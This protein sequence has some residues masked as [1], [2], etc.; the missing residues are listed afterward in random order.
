M[1]F[2]MHHRPGILSLSLFATTLSIGTC[3]IS[4]ADAQDKA[5]PTTSAPTTRPKPPTHADLYAAA[6]KKPL[7]KVV[8]KTPEGVPLSDSQLSEIREA[9]QLLEAARDSRSAGDFEKAKQQAAQAI[10]LFTKNVGVVHYLTIPAG[11][12]S[13]LMD[14]YS[15]VTGPDR[16]ELVEAAKQEKIAD[17]ELK[18]SKFLP[19]RSAA[20]KAIEI[21][22]R[23]LGANSADLI[24][25]LRVLGNAQTELRA[26]DD[27]DRAL[28][29]ALELS[30]RAYG[31]GHPRTAS[32]LD[33]IG[34]LRIYQGKFD[35]AEDA[36]RRAV[37]IY[38][39][40]VG[41]TAETAEAMDNLGTALGYATAADLIE[42]GNHKLRAL[43]IREQTLGP[44]AKDTAVSMSNLSW[45]YSRAGL[46]D[47]V[48]PLRQRAL[49]IFETT[50][51]PE[52]RD[53]QVEKSNLAQAYRSQGKLEEAF[54]L[55]KSMVEQDEKLKLPADQAVINHL[56][57]LGTVSLETG[58]QREG[59]ESLR[60]AREKAMELYAN[61]EYGAAVN[62]MEQI[63]LVYQARRMVEDALDVRAQVLEWD[64]AKQAKVSERMI[65]RSTQL[66]R[67]YCEAGRAKEAVPVLKKAVADAKA[68]HGE[69]ERETTGS[70]IALA[71][72][73]MDAGELEEAS[74]VCGD[75]LRIVES[76]ASKTAVDG[77][78][79]LHTMGKIQ[80]RQ[81]SYDLAKF[82]LEEALGILDQ[83]SRPDP[84]RYV[85][86]QR[87]LA[88]C[89]ANSG[90]VK[91]AVKV[92]NE[93]IA[94]CRQV[95]SPYPMQLKTMQANTLNQLIVVL[96]K[97]PASD[98][99][100]KDRLKAE[101]KTILEELRDGRALTAD[102]KVWMKN[103]GV[104]AGT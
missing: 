100:E 44:K 98:P 31:K 95:K 70:L 17:K 39:T 9:E 80:I 41:E 94:T 104:A 16:D 83:R 66:G 10:E 77:I 1:A 78:F 76:K 59:E 30:E 89:L 62:E 99:A 53:T 60:K 2:G 43:Y 4:S 32:V 49:K 40:S 97:D 65:L 72:A 50:L 7:N 102:M 13:T 64:T 58:K 25:P 38:N 90:D 23:I 87:E 88:E 19:A 46:V 85:G 63:A 67:L 55:Y 86:I 54:E 24:E 51:G 12:L 74:R 57:M 20:V 82:S 96:E 84:V 79:A 101:L 92:M 71:G 28:T 48:I 73:L 14:R 69:G 34:W 11:V 45:L 75:V 3:F 47:E 5:Q 6:S 35:E 81:K 103:Y 93:A 61:D 8:L 36:L 18:D 29:R 33:R 21:R 15:E 22:E 42:A 27:A 91:E 37:F 56:T 68:L 52:H 26:L